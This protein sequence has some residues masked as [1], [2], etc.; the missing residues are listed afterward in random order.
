M[1]SFQAGYLAGVHAMHVAQVVKGRLD[2]QEEFSLPILSMDTRV[3][4]DRIDIVGSES[5]VRRQTI[6]I[7]FTTRISTEE[8]ARLNRSCATGSLMIITKRTT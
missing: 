1:D 6:E 5:F 4:T 7:T 2:G 3:E 8:A